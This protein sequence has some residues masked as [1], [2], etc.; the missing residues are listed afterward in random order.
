MDFIIGFLR[1]S[2]KHD[3]IMVVVDMLI[4]VYHF[5]V[6][7]YENLA[8]EIAHI[9]IREIV[10]LHGVP[11]NTILDRDV[12]FTSRFW[13]ELFAGLGTKLAF[14]T[15]YDLQTDRQTERVD[16]ILKD[17]LDVFHASATEVGVSS[18]SGVFI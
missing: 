6:V 16:Q 4:K 1:I 9:F 5:I 14:S 17:M 8:S 2:R 18:T 12:K 15:A 10:R 7:K 13:K 3:S 11:N